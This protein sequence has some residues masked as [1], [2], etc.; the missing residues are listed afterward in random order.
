[1]TLFLS[2]VFA[3]FYSDENKLLRH[4]QNPSVSETCSSLTFNFWSF[5]TPT[6]TYKSSI[7]L[8]SYRFIIKTYLYLNRL[9]FMSLTVDTTGHL[10]DDFIRLFF[11]Y[12]HR[13]V[14]VLTNELPEES[15]Q[16]RFVRTSYFVNLKCTV[17]L[18]MTKTSVMW[19]TIPWTSHSVFYTVS[20][21]HSFT[22]SHTVSDSFPR[23]CTHHSFSVSP[24]FP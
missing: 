15:D 6:L 11:L 23:T 18:I 1:M 13:E 8:S 17:G 16:F 14:S 3:F 5:I 7:Y 24:S 9:P 20:S 10:Y 19:T 21:F 2:L 4:F 12:S 22:S